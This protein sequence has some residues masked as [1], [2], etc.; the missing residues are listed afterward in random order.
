MSKARIGLIG[1]GRIVQSVHLGILTSLPNVELVAMAEPDEQRRGEASR[2][3]PA[4]KAVAKWEDLLAM[5]DV[6]GV[7]IALPTGMHAAGA[8]A[9]LQAGKHVYLEKPIATNLEDAQAVI[10]TWK[11]SGKIGMVGFNYRYNPLLLSAKKKIEAGAIGQVVAVRSNFCSAARALPTWKQSRVTGGGVLLDLASHHADLARFLF[12]TEVKS[13]HA[14]QR[15]VLSENDAAA[16]E[17]T[18]ENDVVVQSFFTMASADE[19]RWEFYGTKGKII[20]DRYDSVEAQ[21]VAPT[22]PYSRAQKLISLLKQTPY[23]LKVLKKKVSATAEPSFRG[24]LSSFAD[25]I[26]KQQVDV[27]PNLLDGLRSLQVIDAAERSITEGKV[28]IL[29]QSVLLAAS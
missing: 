13:V 18:L 21:F 3:A 12:N 4:A 5:S 1:C 23:G 14:A 26:A 7:V 16:L 27:K 17:L 24:A 29:E 15:S 9:A 22:K 11:T 2:R 8:I 28:A 25:A 19:D 10:D 6:Q 20:V